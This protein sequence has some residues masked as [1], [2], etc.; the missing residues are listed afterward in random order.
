[1][2]GDINLYAFGPEHASTVQR[3]ED[4]GSD[5]DA[6]TYSDTLKFSNT[7]DVTATVHGE[8][9]GGK[10]DCVDMNRAHDCTVFAERW[11]PRGLFLA[12]IKGG[13]TD[14]YLSGEVVAHGKEVDVDLGNWSDQSSAKTGAGMLDLRSHDGSPI[15]IRVLNAERPHLEPSS[16]PYRYAFPSPNLGGFLHKTIVLGWLLLRRLGFFR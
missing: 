4:A 1:M 13:T 9:A 2:S 14:Y 11:H 12:T 10:E 5:H 7:H 8:L 6:A 16:G 3:F 15:V